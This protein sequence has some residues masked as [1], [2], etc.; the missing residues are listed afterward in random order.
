MKQWC[1][2]KTLL[3]VGEGLHDEAFLRHV[4]HLFAPRGCGLVVTVK[5]AHGKGALNVVNFAIRQRAS[6][7]YDRCVVMTDTDTDYDDRVVALAAGRNIKIIA[8]HPCIE[9]L[10]L[11]VLKKKPGN[12]K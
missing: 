6:A 1:I 3:L 4:K 9:A 10:L 8:S 2:R 11:R 7:D 12:P 5:N